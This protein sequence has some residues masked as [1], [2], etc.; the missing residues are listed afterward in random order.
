M[1]L[2]SWTCAWTTADE[3]ALLIAGHPEVLLCIT[4]PSLSGVGCGCGCGVA[5]IR[6][7]RGGGCGCLLP[8]R[9]AGQEAAGRTAEIRRHQSH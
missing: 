8:G 2:K 5:K 7:N 3:K 1:C 6:L 4:W 9:P